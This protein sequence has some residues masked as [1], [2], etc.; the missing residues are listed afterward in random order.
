MRL[1]RRRRVE[2]HG[3]SAEKNLSLI[4]TIGPGQNLHQ[5]RFARP[6]IANECT[7][8]ARINGEVC[9]I[10]SSNMTEPSTDA[11]SLEQRRFH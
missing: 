7:Y 4:G 2:L 11:A 5:G 6:I 9:S 3:R 1:R 8:L 10:E